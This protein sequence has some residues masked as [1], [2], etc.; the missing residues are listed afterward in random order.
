MDKKFEIFPRVY[1]TRE[2][3]KGKKFTKACDKVEAKHTPSSFYV[4]NPIIQDDEE[5]EQQEQSSSV[6]DNQGQRK[7][8]LKR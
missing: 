3:V 8:L 2:I 4:D 6:S 5:D 7:N 1:L